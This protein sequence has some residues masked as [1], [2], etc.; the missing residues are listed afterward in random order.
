MNIIQLIKDIEK[1]DT[2]A[3]DRLE[4]SR[5]KVFKHLGSM[6]KK[7][8]LTA[9]PF[10]LG[11]VFNKASAQ[12]S[13]IQQVLD[14]ALTLEHLENEFYITALNKSGLIP[15]TDRA[16]FEQIQKHEQAH[17][18]FLSTALGSAA[19][20]KPTFD[21]TGGNGSGNGPYAAIITNNDYQLFLTVAQALEDTGVRAYKGQAANLMSDDT[22]LTQ[23]LQIHSVEARHAAE[24]RR[25]RNL[26][27][28]IIGD[29]ANGAPQP[30]YN[31]EA[32]TT[33]EGVNIASFTGIDADEASAAF[34]EPLTKQQVLDIADPFIV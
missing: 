2:E 3:A 26:K 12:G 13:Q 25:L 28:W 22:V 5:R 30:V 17:V 11:T 1:V 18:Y 4:F 6:G 34:D 10:A 20:P 24:V 14:F 23:A 33:Q 19:S 15:Q 8:V 7:M 32:N 16:I 31:G 27:G 21:F 9:A 29:Q